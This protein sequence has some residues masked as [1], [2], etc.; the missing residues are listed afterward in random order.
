M[1]LRPNLA[2]RQLQMPENG[3]FDT[4]VES[5]NKNELFA[6]PEVD[7]LWGKKFKLRI[8]SHGTGKEIDVNFRFNVKVK[9]NEENKKVN[10]IC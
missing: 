10:L 3:K 9:Q 8:R 4:L 1:S 7:G 6:T 2:Q 5:S